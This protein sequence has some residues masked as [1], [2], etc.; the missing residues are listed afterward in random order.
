MSEDKN[1]KI[2]RL[3]G[4]E[5]KARDARSK[6]ELNFVVVNETREIISYTNSFLLIKSASNNYN[7][8]AISDLAT[9]DRTS[10]L[11]SYVEKVINHKS[12]SNLKDI[13]LI[14]L[15]DF[16]KTLKIAKPKNI[17]Q[18]ILC[19]PIFSPQKGL[20]GYLILSRND[21]FQEN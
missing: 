21:P 17:P 4:L 18:F 16:S 1:I 6:D 13:T 9:V 20:Q 11:V 2:A 14:D 3:I 19:V 15:N 10:P 12:N 5:K 8:S 7:V